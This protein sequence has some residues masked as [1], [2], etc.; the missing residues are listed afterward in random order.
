MLPI[1]AV[2][3]APLQST[4]IRNCFDRTE[5]AGTFGGFRTLIPFVVAYIN[6][7]G[8][9]SFDVLLGVG[10]SMIAVGFFYKTP[11][12][13][14]PMKGDRGCRHHPGGQD[15]DGEGQHRVRCAACMRSAA[16]RSW[17]FIRFAV[18]S[19]DQLV[20]QKATKR[21]RFGSYLCSVSKAGSTKTILM[22]LI[23][24][25]S[26]SP[27]CDGVRRCA[28]RRKPMR[29]SVGERIVFVVM[30]ISP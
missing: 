22:Q 28:A 21:A 24:P 4:P 19:A 16:S 29:S 30:R 1:D 3:A 17:N 25:E 8:L 15:G 7:L 13:V 18:S 12:P 5:L 11:F 10:A 9:G 6:L 23:R 26:Q 14:Q 2:R 20:E 27:L